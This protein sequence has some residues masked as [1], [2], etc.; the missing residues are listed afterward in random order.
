MQDFIYSRSPVRQRW[1]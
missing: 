1:N